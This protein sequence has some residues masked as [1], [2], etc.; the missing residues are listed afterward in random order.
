MRREPFAARRGFYPSNPKALAA[1]LDRLLPTGGKPRSV[2]AAVVPHAGLS[3]SGEVAGKVYAAIEVP[4][5]VVILCP[6]HTPYGA[7]LG[8]MTAGTWAMPGFEVE[9]DAALAPAILKACRL[10][11]DEEAHLAEHSLEVQLPFLFRRNPA[12]R[13]TPI[14]VGA[15]RYDALRTLGERRAGAVRV[16]GEPVLLLASSDMSHE[17]GTAR[18]KKNDALAIERMLALDAQGLYETVAEHDITMCGF[19]PATAVLTAAV[20]LG[21]KKAEL[22]GYQTSLDHGGT[23]DWVV[24]YAG[25]VFE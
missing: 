22:L 14:A 9:V 15:H 16:F 21:A 17:Q 19:A 20:A 18:G 1:E 13:L 3:Y 7:S 25:L 5:H 10:E 11:E 12:F 8:I 2:V 6:K 4:E 23:P 24:G